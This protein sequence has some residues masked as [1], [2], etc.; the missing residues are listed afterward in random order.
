MMCIDPF[1]FDRR[2]LSGSSIYSLI[3]YF[4]HPDPHFVTRSFPDPDPDHDHDIIN[5]FN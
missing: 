3:R 2:S 4:S 1:F 5:I